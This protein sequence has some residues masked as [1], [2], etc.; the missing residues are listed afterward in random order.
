M[1][2]DDPPLSVH[3]TFVFPHD[4]Y[5]SIIQ[6]A[7]M[8]ASRQTWLRGKK[9]VSTRTSTCTNYLKAMPTY[10]HLSE[11]MLRIMLDPSTFVC[12][13]RLT[14]RHKRVHV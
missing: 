4:Q 7:P 5:S 1:Q 6:S 11:A 8:T 3:V 9:V 2:Y 10:E 12:V 14:L 13:L